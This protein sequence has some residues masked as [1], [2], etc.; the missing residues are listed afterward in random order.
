LIFVP[1]GNFLPLEI[2][3][4]IPRG[5]KIPCENKS[6]ARYPRRLVRHA[7]KGTGFARYW[8]DYG[9]WYMCEYYIEQQL[10]VFEGVFVCLQ[11]P[12]PFATV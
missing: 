5:Q 10:I 12:V 3:T 2:H 1:T 9:M 4:D 7:G 11:S 6:T 8:Q